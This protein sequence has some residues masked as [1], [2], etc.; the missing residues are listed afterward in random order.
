MS[1]EN[2]YNLHSKLDSKE[3]PSVQKGLEQISKIK[4]ILETFFSNDIDISKW[5]F[6]GVLGSVEMSDHVRYCSD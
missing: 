5:R 1:L 4:T 3:K 2:K 6:V